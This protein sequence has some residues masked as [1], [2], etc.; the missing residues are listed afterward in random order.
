MSARLKDLDG[1]MSGDGVATCIGKILKKDP[2]GEDTLL[3][4]V[5]VF[6]FLRLLLA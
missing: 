6:S 4:D 3:A 5:T 2:E 1:T